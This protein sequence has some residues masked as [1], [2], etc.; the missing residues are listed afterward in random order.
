MEQSCTGGQGSHASAP[1]GKVAGVSDMFRALE[2][3]CQEV[4]G[5]CEEVGV[6]GCLKSVLNGD[7]V[8]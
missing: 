6:R 5:V 7:Q 4:D 1:P 3:L 2:E 8:K